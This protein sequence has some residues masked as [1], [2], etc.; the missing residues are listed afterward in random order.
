MNEFGF[1]SGLYYLL[2]ILLT[3]QILRASKRGMAAAVFQRTYRRTKNRQ[4]LGQRCRLVKLAHD[5][6]AVLESQNR[7][8]QSARV[9]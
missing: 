1:W 3:S 5:C 4:A 9:L 2:L 7:V 8:I 6:R